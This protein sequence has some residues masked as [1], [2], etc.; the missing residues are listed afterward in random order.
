MVALVVIQ[1][2][3][4][5]DSIPNK[6]MKEAKIKCDSFLS[7]YYGENIFKKH[8]VCNL[9]TSFTNCETENGI[10]I[11]HF[12]ES[13]EYTPK[14]YDLTY[15]IIVDS[16]EVFRFR[17]SGDKN[18]VFS[19]STVSYWTNKFEGYKNLLK[20]E[21]RISYAE[22]VSIAKKNGFEL[23]NVKIELQFNESRFW[24]IEPQGL[25]PNETAK[26]LHIDVKTGV[27]TEHIIGL[28]IIE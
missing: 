2:G 9:K 4:S 15:M 8:F 16:T 26:T 20:G 25:L 24:S 19:F 28:I 10:K 23:S 14:F 6:S 12:N 5:Q 17:I 11:F 21:F 27:V 22:A 7:S 1:S 3:Y 13:F 18:G